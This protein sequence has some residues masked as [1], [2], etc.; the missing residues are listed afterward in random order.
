MEAGELITTFNSIREIGISL[1]IV[2]G[3][4]GATLLMM[5]WLG[6]STPIVRDEQVD[7]C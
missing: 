4:L 5:L 2:L 1:A 3:I 7:E 6:K